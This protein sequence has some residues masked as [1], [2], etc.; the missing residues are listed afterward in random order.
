[1]MNVSASP[2]VSDIFFSS[3]FVIHVCTYAG[4]YFLSVFLF[5]SGVL[6]VKGTLQNSSNQQEPPPASHAHIKN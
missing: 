6:E 2:P 5:L 3:I 1:M 4:G